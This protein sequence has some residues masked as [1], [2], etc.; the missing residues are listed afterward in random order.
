MFP[1]SKVENWWKRGRKKSNHNANDT[2]KTN[3]NIQIFYDIKCTLRNVIF[4]FT[5][6]YDPST[7]SISLTKEVHYVTL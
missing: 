4:I 6:N 2:C 1:E 3:H 7:L 5:L